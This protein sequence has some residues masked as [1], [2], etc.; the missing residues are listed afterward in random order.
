MSDPIIELTFELENEESKVFKIY[1]TDTQEEAG[2]NINDTDPWRHDHGE[3]LP[4]RT[5]KV[6]VDLL[7]ALC[8]AKHESDTYLTSILAKENS[9]SSMSKESKKRPLEK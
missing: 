2:K 3:L 4:P 6:G 5:P 1:E 7:K 8:A 9:I